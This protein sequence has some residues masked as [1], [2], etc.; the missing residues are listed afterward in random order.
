[1]VM[2]PQAELNGEMQTMMKMAVRGGKALGKCSL[3]SA[4]TGFM[5]DFRCMASSF[6]YSSYIWR[7]MSYHSPILKSSLRYVLSISKKTFGPA[8]ASSS[9]WALS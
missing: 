9:S 4:L 8:S 3:I 1:M 7:F 5:L 2:E 6:V